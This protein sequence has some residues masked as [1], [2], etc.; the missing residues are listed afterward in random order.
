MLLQTPGDGQYASLTE[1]GL[2][3][4]SA[5]CSPAGGAQDCNTSCL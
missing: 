5:F 2:P 4:C 1:A 3:V